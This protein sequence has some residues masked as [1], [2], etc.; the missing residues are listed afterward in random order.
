MSAATGY[1]RRQQASWAGPIFHI[2][3]F[4]IRTRPSFNLTAQSLPRYFC[5]IV[6]GGG[7]TG[8]PLTSCTTWIPRARRRSCPSAVIHDHC[9]SCHHTGPQ[10]T[11]LI[12][13][14][15]RQKPQ[16][17]SRLIGGLT[18]FNPVNLSQTRG[19]PGARFRGGGATHL[20]VPP[21]T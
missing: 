12:L 18:P 4:L 20:S 19:N 14:Q 5:P 11:P 2:A 13:T 17:E 1:S 6:C 15:V 21:N 8:L 16:N 10:A 7:G 9:T 3:L